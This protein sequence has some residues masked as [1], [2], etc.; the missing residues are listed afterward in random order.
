M[1]HSLDFASGIICGENRPSHERPPTHHIPLCPLRYTFYLP[2]S[3]VSL[4]KHITPFYRISNSMS[5]TYIK[6]S[7]CHLLIVQHETQ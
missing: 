1:A 6:Q 2:L 3:E 7:H 5:N 4:C